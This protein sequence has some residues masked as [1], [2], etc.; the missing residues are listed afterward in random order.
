MLSTPIRKLHCEQLVGKSLLE[1]IE[2]V[3]QSVSL[4]TQLQQTPQAGNV[5]VKLNS[6]Q[7]E[8]QELEH[9]EGLSICT[10]DSGHW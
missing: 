10:E 3:A 8:S 2:F 6:R 7:A 4:L 5:F 1:K 9:H